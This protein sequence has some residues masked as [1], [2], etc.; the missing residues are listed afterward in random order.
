ML[1]VEPTLGQ[2]NFLSIECCACGYSRWRKPGHFYSEKIR[3]TTP[4]SVLSSKLRCPSCLEDG[5][6][7]DDIAIEVAWKLDR[8]RVQ[9]ANWR[10]KNILKRLRFIGESTLWWRIILL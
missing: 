4:L 5:W 6:P 3:P 9:A 8:D 1:S 10:L 2:V 7:G